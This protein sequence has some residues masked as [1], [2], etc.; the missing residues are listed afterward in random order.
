[1]RYS[2]K[3]SEIVFCT[4]ERHMMQFRSL[5]LKWLAKFISQFQLSI[6]M[7]LCNFSMGLNMFCNVIP[8]RII[9]LEI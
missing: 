6:W 8:V 4:P 7:S 1:M 5:K 3:Q 9:Y 2:L